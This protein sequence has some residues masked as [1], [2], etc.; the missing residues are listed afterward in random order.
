MDILSGFLF[1]IALWG[2]VLIYVKLQFFGAVRL[3]GW[4][5]SAALLPPLFMVPAIVITASAFN[6]GSKLWFLPLML[7]SPFAAI[8]LAILIIRCHAAR[9]R[10]RAE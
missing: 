10:K 2:P 8:Y 1:S 6:Q 7:T 3:N 9:R 5:R 4:W